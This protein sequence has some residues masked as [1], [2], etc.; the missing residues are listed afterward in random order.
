MSGHYKIDTSEISHL[1]AGVMQKINDHQTVEHDN[2]IKDLKMFIINHK[3]ELQL[4]LKKN[5][6]GSIVNILEFDNTSSNYRIVVLTILDN[7]RQSLLNEILLTPDIKLISHKSVSPNPINGDLKSK[8]NYNIKDNS[9]ASK[10]TRLFLDTLECYIPN[11]PP[12]IDLSKFL[13]FSDNDFILTDDNNWC[14]YKDPL[15]KTVICLDP[16]SNKIISEK[17]DTTPYEKI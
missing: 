12:F 13:K 10:H 9:Q 16:K 14:F 7:H 5:N 2:D 17:N 8:N 1:G 11:T 3:N 4:E 15:N 6:L